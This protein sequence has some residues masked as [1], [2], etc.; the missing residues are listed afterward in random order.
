MSTSLP[1]TAPVK[2]TSPASVGD[3][4]RWKAIVVPRGD[5][6]DS[7]SRG[8]SGATA[9]AAPPP[10]ATTTTNT[11][12]AHNRRTAGSL[13]VEQNRTRRLNTEARFDGGQP[14]QRASPAA[15]RR[16]T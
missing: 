8:T 9:R 4:A 14:A 6:H 11:T 3:A 1:P 15:I 10:S 5:H 12:P 2:N 7:T 16:L 13:P